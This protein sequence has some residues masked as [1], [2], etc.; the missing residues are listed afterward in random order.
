MKV[1][2]KPSGPGHFNPSLALTASSISSIVKGGIQPHPTMTGST[3][4][5]KNAFGKKSQ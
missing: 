1:K 2:L 3:P 5:L 4:H